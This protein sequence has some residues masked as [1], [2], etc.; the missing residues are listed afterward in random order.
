MELGKFKEKTGVNPEEFL[1]RLT[2]LK[3]KIDRHK[4]ENESALLSI[5][6]TVVLV[7]LLDGIAKA[8]DLPDDIVRAAVML[9]SIIEEIEAVEKEE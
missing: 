2:A 9:E 5:E 1:S 4:V 6:L 8:S 3:E 7:Y